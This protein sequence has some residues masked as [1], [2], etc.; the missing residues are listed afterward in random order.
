MNKSFA[1]NIL[2]LPFLFLATALS[3]GAQQK[4]VL[5]TTGAGSVTVTAASAPVINTDIKITAATSPTDLARAALVSLGGEKYL[6]LDNMV[7]SGSADLYAPNQTT[8]LP[9]KF[10]MV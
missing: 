1:R 4:E 9:G 5:K 3:A 2:A 10:V 6:K 8:A 7:L